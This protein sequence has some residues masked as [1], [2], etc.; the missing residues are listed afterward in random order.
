LSA[1]EF[2]EQC[3]QF[4]IVENGEFLKVYLIL[5]GWRLVIRFSRF[6]NQAL[7]HYFW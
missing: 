7:L 6:N 3:P 2:S 5:F 1:K 4:D